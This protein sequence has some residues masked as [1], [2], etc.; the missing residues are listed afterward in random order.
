V[1][2]QLGA[3]RVPRRALAGVAGVAGVGAMLADALLHGGFHF[4]AATM[5]LAALLAAVD[6]REGRI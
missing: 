2:D 3:V 4:F 5:V 1:A 6:P